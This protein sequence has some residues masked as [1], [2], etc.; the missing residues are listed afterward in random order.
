MTTK[1]KHYRLKRSAL[2]A[3]VLLVLIYALGVYSALFIELPETGRWVA[4][5]SSLIPLAHAVLGTLLIFHSGYLVH[6]S[7]KAKNG[8]WI[9]VSWI[10]LAGV[11]LSVI[12]GFGYIST[13]N[14]LHTFLMAL[15]FALSVL[16]YVYGLYADQN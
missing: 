4:F 16:A 1:V 5:M 9:K 10:G 7:G 2:A 15:G 12:T 6:Q 13:D 14:D 3:I 8:L 11:F